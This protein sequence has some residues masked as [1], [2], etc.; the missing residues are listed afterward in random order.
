[1]AQLPG[2]SDADGPVAAH[3]PQVAS[4]RHADELGEMRR[5]EDARAR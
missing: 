1:M 2:D 4:Q 3:S 5:E